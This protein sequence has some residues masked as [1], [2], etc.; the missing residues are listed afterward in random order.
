MDAPK[1][2]DTSICQRC[3]WSVAAE[4]YR[5]NLMPQR[6]ET[7][8]QRAV[9]SWLSGMGDGTCPKFKEKPFV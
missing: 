3:I 5:C 7:P 1:E 8:A 6:R 9:A 4:A 2:R